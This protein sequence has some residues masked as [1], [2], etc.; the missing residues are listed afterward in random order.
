VVEE[1]TVRDGLVTSE[2]VPAIHAVADGHPPELTLA[3]TP[4]TSPDQPPPAA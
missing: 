1:L 2:L 3:A 4:A